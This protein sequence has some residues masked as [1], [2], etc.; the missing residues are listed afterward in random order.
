MLQNSFLVEMNF[1]WVLCWVV[2]VSLFVAAANVSSSR[3][4]V[5]NIGA[6]FNIDSVVGK[7]AKIALVEAVKDVNANS[8]IL[9]GTKLVLTMQSSN[10]SGFI[11]MVQALRFM[12]TDVVA[13]IGPQSSVVA[14]IISHVANELRVPLL[15]FAATDPTLSSLQFP[16][17]VRT[18]Q[19]DLYQMKAVA[20]IIDYYGWKEVIAIYVDDDYGRNGVAALDDELAAR[21]CKISFKEGIQSGTEVDRGQITSLLVKVALMQ[22]RVIVLHAQTDSGFMLFNVARYLGMTDNGYVWIV[23]DWLSSLLDSFS[24]PSE[25]MDVL[26]GV[27]VLRQHTP[28]SDRKRVFLSRWNNLTGG[29]LGLHSYGLYAYDSVWLVARAIDA[30]FSQG[31]IVSCTNYTTGDKGGELNLNA[32][33]IFDNG[34]LLLKNILQS[35]FVGLSGRMKFQ[36][37]RSLVQPAYDILNVV[38]TGLRRVG[39]WSNYSGLSI[40]SPEILYAKPPNRS[41]ANQKLH[42]V[43]WPGDTLSK[44]RGWVFP[45]NGRQLRIGVPIRVSYREFVSPVK[46]TEMFKGFCVDVFTAAVNLLPYAVP[47]RFVPFGDGHQN[48]S[49]TELVN[50]IT[51]GFFDGA[52]GDIAIVTNRT[53][54]VDFTQPYAASGLVVVAPFKK[55]NSGGWSFLRPFT[56]LM[57]IVTVCFFFF[58]GLVVWILEHRIND[59][60]RGPP[61]QQI[62]TMLWFSLST[63]FFSH[64]ENTMS[65]LGRLVMLIWL[66]VVLILT[67]SYTASLTSILTVQQLSSSINGIDSLKAS[68][69]PIGFQVGSFAEH[70]L[71]QDIGISKSRLVPLGSPEEYANALQLGPKKG[72][73]AAIVDERP[74]VEIFLST[75][76]TFRIVGQEFTRSGWGFAFPRDSPLAVDMSTAILQLSETGD[77]QRI[78]DK[79][80]T[81]SSCSLDNAEIDSDRLKL[82]SFWGL[83]LICG[84]ACFVALLLH[85]LQLMFQLWQF[86]P[87]EPASS[88]NTISGRFQRFLALIDEKK[89]PSRSKGRKRNGDESSLDDQPGRQPKRV[90]IM[91]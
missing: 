58:I 23:T 71:V 49:Y 5:V 54:I 66:F 52:I 73:V 20:E 89:D 77:L 82:K 91:A 76:C 40:V 7:V 61:R 43:I 35:D 53:R 32:M 55:I 28:D 38:G 12:E 70:Y 59:E 13:I 30:F 51:T 17:F 74:Y 85:F 1:F 36:P 34:T 83:F 19:S 90:Q 37:D 6:I 25:T 64:R 56:P 39:Y 67:S 22:S 18:T 47:Y 84:I 24:L 80:M 8:N 42:S 57:W 46:G 33:S 9:N 11:G 44:P 60:F 79:W 41:S 15:S 29:S 48:P 65:T 72:G 69:E 45:N 78:H 21:R 3:P 62:I 27:L 10:S 68:D 75:Q 81:R 2:S 4:A 50:L 26:Q 87:S 31:G 63:L 86:P 16:F 88:A 14:H